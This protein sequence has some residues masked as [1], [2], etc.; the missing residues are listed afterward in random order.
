MPHRPHSVPD[1]HPPMPNLDTTSTVISRVH[2]SALTPQ[3]FAEQYQCP[4][5]PVVVDGLLAE[6]VDWT[7]DYLC[8]QLRDHP[9]LIR[10]Y[11]QQR[12]QQDKRQWSNIGSGCDVIQLPF[13][14]YAQRLRSREAH[15]RDMYLAKCPIGQTALGD[16]NPLTEIGSRLGLHQP[17]SDFNLWVGPSGHVECLHYDPMDGT[18]VQ[19]HGEKKVILFAPQQSADLYPFPI[20]VHLRHGLRMRCWFSQVTLLNPD[21]E[22][23]PNFRQAWPQRIE[24]ILK[25]G[26]TLYIP[27]GW[28]HEVTALGTEM[29]CSVNR[30]WRVYPASRALFAWQR[31]RTYLG[32]ASAVPHTIGSL[33]LALFSHQRQAKIAEIFAID[34]ALGPVQ[35]RALLIRG[36]TYGD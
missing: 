33:L 14:D 31:W 18:L 12:Y 11:G 21:F 24:V 19:L 28:W 1:P 15:E 22:S 29:S 10:C 23:F 3:A 26:E 25:A 8:E 17:I 2:A 36:G 7:L 27:A 5:K 9:F 13:L 16:V 34:L 35:N 4:G 30:F 20:S 32:S 6:D